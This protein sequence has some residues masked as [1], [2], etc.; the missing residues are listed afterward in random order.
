MEACM[1]GTNF[2]YLF[3]CYKLSQNTVAKTIHCFISHN[4][5]CFVIFISHNSMDHQFEQSTERMAHP[6]TMMPGISA[7]II[8]IAGDWNSQRLPKHFSLSLSVCLY[9]YLHPLHIVSFGF[10]TAIRLL[11]WRFK[12]FKRECSKTQGVDTTSLLRPTS[13]SK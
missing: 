2:R 3:L 4:S 13:W 6:D 1:R 11:I 9:L 5:K 7:R 12:C 8:K 10:L